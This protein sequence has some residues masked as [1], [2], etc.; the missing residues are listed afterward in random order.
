MVDVQSELLQHVFFV[1]EIEDRFVMTVR[2]DERF[3]FQLR[4][5]AVLFKQKLRQCLHRFR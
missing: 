5:L 3:A 4:E 2:L 1:I